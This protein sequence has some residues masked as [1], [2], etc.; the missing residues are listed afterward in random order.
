ML[1]PHNIEL[2]PFPGICPFHKDCWEG[3]ASGPA[4]RERWGMPGQDI[5]DDHPAWDLEAHYNALAIVN[6][7]LSYSPY[8]I[9][10]GGGVSQHPGLMERVRREVKSVL[11]GYV[12]APV[13][14]TR[15]DDYIIPPQCG[16]QSGGIGALV[17]AKRFMAE[18]PLEKG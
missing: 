9:V 14:E 18:H 4:M 11:N 6:L 7:I 16:N 2:D 1:I 8:R 12:Q 15:L 17:M 10:L 5:P 13:M 3:L